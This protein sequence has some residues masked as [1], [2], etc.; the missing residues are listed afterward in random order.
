[1]SA[2]GLFAFGHRAVTVASMTCAHPSD[3]RQAVY[4]GGRIARSDRTWC[5]LCGAVVFGGIETAQPFGTQSDNGGAS[6]RP[7]RPR[8][9][10]I[11]VGASTNR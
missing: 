10:A 11:S 2:I 6:D 8:E 3:E 1:M 9:R 5:S 4:D 7:R